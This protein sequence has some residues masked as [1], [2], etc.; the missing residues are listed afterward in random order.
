MSDASSHSVRLPWRSVVEKYSVSSR[1]VSFG[2]CLMQRVFL[3]SDDVKGTVAE[4]Q[5]SAQSVST[6]VTIS[7]LVAVNESHR[8]LFVLSAAAHGAYVHVLQEYVC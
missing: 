5:P 1:T 2:I 3:S 4:C 6:N 8:F 7:Q